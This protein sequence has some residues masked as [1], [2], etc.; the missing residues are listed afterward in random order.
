MT[1]QSIAKPKMTDEFTLRMLG[2]NVTLLRCAWLELLDE[3][4]PESETA[5]RIREMLAR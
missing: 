2:D 4:R 1:T 5:G 3:L